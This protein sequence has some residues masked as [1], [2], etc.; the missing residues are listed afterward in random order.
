MQ[1]VIFVDVAQTNHCIPSKY[2]LGRQPPAEGWARAGKYPL[3]KQIRN[4]FWYLLKVHKII[5]YCG[6]LSVSEQLVADIPIVYTCQP[7]RLYS[8]PFLSIRLKS[9]KFNV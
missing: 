4:F 9:R 3:I 1:F 7:A 6:R 8:L 2:D 5:S